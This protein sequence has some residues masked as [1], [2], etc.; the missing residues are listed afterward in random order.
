MC[1]GVPGAQAVWAFPQSG[2]KFAFAKAL[3]FLLVWNQFF[4]KFISLGV[5]CMNLDSTPMLST[6]L[7]F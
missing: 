7:E 1:V 6:S 4:C 3:Q 5:G 2:S